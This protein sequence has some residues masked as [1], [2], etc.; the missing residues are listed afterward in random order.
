M[1]ENQ[2]LL[3]QLI[4]GLIILGIMIYFGIIKYTPQPDSDFWFN[5]PIYW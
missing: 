5:N 1:S 3:I 4:I 2:K